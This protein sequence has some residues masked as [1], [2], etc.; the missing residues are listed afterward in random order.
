MLK[1]AALGTVLAYLQTK[2]KPLFFLDSHGGRGRYDL[3]APEALRSGEYR[4]GIA[5]LSAA[6]DTPPPF[7]PYLHAIRAANPDGGLAT[8]PGSPLM[9]AQALRVQDRLVACELNLQ[10][11]GHLAETLY[12]FT[13]AKVREGD[14]YG[15]LKALLPP[16]ERRGLVLIDP[17]FEKTTEFADL[18]EALRQAW[19][20][21]PVG[22]YLVWYPL[23]DRSAADRFLGEVA[24]AGIRDAAVYE[25]FVRDPAS[26]TG[27]AGSGILAINAS[28]ALRTMA[29]AGPWLAGL[30]AQGP[31]ARFATMRLTPE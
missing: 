30:L 20:R 18:A 23:K 25:L 24:A 10:E 28:Y 2:E 4:Q 6:S 12:P 11:A 15:A 19:K 3:S 17:P 29:D 7:L 22:V 21:F 31:G 1:H 13:R 26:V 27:M 8:Y 9:I 14:G 16:P 5:R